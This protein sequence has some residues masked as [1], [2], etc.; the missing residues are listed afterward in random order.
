MSKLMSH[1]IIKAK[2]QAKRPSALNIAIWNN[3]TY[4]KEKYTKRE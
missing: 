2:Y 1:T 3:T 4:D